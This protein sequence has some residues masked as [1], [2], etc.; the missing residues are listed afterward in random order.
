MPRSG[1]FVS[2]INT[3]RSNDGTLIRP[4]SGTSHLL[5][6][7][8]VVSDGKGPPVF[9]LKRVTGI[10]I[11]GKSTSGQQ[12]LEIEARHQ[13]VRFLHVKRVAQ[14]DAYLLQCR[15]GCSFLCSLSQSS[16]RRNASRLRIDFRERFED[17]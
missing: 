13:T 9:P 5:E 7:L 14:D 16:I 2:F 4:F 6:G 1:T 10:W 12:L 8:I 11:K 15:R 3:N 17:Q